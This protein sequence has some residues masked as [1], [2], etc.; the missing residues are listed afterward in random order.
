[1]KSTDQ[2]N[3]V[4]S[5]TSTSGRKDAAELRQRGDSLRD[6]GKYG[7]AADA[8]GTYLALEPQDFDIWVQRGNCL[9]DS[10]A[11]SQAAA[12]YE[13]AL[14]L[15]PNDADV[16]LQMGHLHKL[17]GHRSDAIKSYKRSA[18]LDPGV[19]AL[20]ELRALGVRVKLDHSP[21][22]SAALA[23][24]PVIYLDVT[25][26]LAFLRDF[27]R[28]T[29]IQRVQSCILHHALTTLGC[30]YGFGDK[31]NDGNTIITFFDHETRTIFALSPKAVAALLRSLLWETSDHE[32]VRAHVTRVIDSGAVVETRNIDTYVILGAFW[33]VPN[34]AS[35][36][37]SL[38][39]AGTKLG[40]Y[41]YDLIPI[42]HP[43]HVHES[44]REEVQDRFSEVMYMVDF[45]LT[46]SSF[47]AS[48]V[49]EV[50]GREL[51]LKPPVAPVLLAHELI[52][53]VD[54]EEP[55][56]DFRTTLPKEYVLCVCT[57]EARKN[58]AL[59]VNA[60]S[61]LKR[62]Y[63]S[64]LP[65]LVLV[66]RWGWYVDELRARLEATDYLDGTIVVLGNLSDAELKYA[67]ENCLFTV[68]PSF[69]EGWGL[70]VGES[71]A[72]G[73]PCIASNA[74][75]IP[76]VG[77]DFC[78]YINPYDEVGA[79]AEIERA[80][81]DRDALRKWTARIAADFSVRTWESVTR[82]FMQTVADLSREAKVGAGPAPRV[83]AGRVHRLTKHALQK[84]TA[85]WSDRL[86]RLAAVDGWRQFEAWGAWSSRRT[87]TIE[88]ATGL[89]GG[90][91]V[92]VLL[93]LRI[94][95][96]AE[97][98]VV[99][100]H[101]ANDITTSVTFETLEARWAAVDAS[102]D[103]S[104]CVRLQVE[105]VGDVKHLD[106]TREL[107]CGLSA[108]AYHVTTDISARLEILETLLLEQDQGR[109]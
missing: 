10:A 1:M 95:P 90:T 16:H 109:S 20:S 67:Y 81:M 78:R 99:L 37:R 2:V 61:T 21:L 23:N 75:S 71:L 43:Q 52:D 107:H 38:K 96:P 60:W 7:D 65:S 92:R 9:K 58:H 12:A 33:V 72:Y 28:V 97:R 45:V 69:A 85:S 59:L 101:G 4:T 39:R 50:V 53:S 47:V 36:M 106:S 103:E 11:F 70:P 57:I 102:T 49:R 17:Q 104:G 82:S 83:S 87:A 63:G 79:T 35:L 13:T 74:T 88:L 31:A 89:P 64:N 18:Q 86:V 93:E 5:T 40:V 98:G 91:A 30:V 54:E 41:I 46:I 8:Y 84:P 100:V 24:R 48:E 44:T 34:Y 80:L 76:E 73:R 26:L 22:V 3:R 68:F 42:T 6:A 19:G 94:A 62:K 15:R 32:T 51:N 56:E 77:G 108:I 25:D 66:G 55:G 105:R 14:R 27:H 29:G